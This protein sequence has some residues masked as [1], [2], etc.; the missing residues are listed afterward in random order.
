MWPCS[1]TDGGK[2]GKEDRES[3]WRSEKMKIK[4]LIIASNEAQDLQ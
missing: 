3:E 4:Q 2:T 1:N